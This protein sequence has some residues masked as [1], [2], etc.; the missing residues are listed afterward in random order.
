MAFKRKTIATYKTVGKRLKEARRKLEL[1]L[2]E[3]EEATKV[4]SKYL[5]AI[6]AD[7]WRDF[8]SRVYVLGFVRR[9][10]EFLKLDAQKII[11]DF[12]SEFGENPRI[13]S[14]HQRGFEKSAP[15]IITPRVIASAAIIVFI[16]VLVGY[17]IYSV[18]KFSKPPQITI[19]SPVQEIVSQKNTVI[20]GKTEATAAVEINNQSVNVDDAGRFTQAVE[21]TAGVNY[22]EIR[23]KNRLGRESTKVVKILYESK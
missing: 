16:L 8:P 22:Y 6:E 4:R 9:Y 21:L 14:R 11:S 7:R 13:F 23:A 20:E 19:S 2:E 5:S 1:S 15:F 17:I 10:S 3:A 18:N 12:N